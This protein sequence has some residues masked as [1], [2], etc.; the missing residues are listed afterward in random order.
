MTKATNDFDESTKTTK[1]SLVGTASTERI[2]GR[3][4]LCL[5]IHSNDLKAIIEEV[6]EVKIETA[7]CLVNGA[8]EKG[9]FRMETR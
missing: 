6:K 7:E 5:G 9:K 2:V 1:N 8:F 4:R 3:F